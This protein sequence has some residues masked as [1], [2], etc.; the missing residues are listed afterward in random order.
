ML[1]M[2]VIRNVIVSFFYRL[3][4]CS[5]KLIVYLYKQ[6]MFRNILMNHLKE[7]VLYSTRDNFCRRRGA[8]LRAV[9]LGFDSRQRRSAD[10]SSHHR[11][12]IDF[13]I[14]WC[15]LK[16]VPGLK[17]LY[18]PCH[19]VGWEYVDSCVQW[20]FMACK[21]DNFHTLD[22]AQERASLI[23]WSSE[24]STSAKN[25]T[26]KGQ[27]PN[28]KV[29]TKIPDTVGNRVRAAGVKGGDSTD[30]ATAADT[31]TL[32]NIFKYWTTIVFP[33]AFIW[34]FNIRK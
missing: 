13:G 11:D 27:T 21:Q 5:K 9:W 22:R 33:A 2:H 16:W 24:C 28:L 10:F 34:L 20:L 8:W 1:H 6:S 14:Q 29:G 12:Q 19:A 18:F 26:H 17:S 32:W 23:L 30:Y 7:E 31:N 25:S 15:S 4:R 3:N